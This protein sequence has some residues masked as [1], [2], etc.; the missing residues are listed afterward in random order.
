MHAEFSFLIIMANKAAVSSDKIQVDGMIFFTL[1]C[2]IRRLKGRR[3]QSWRSMAIRNKVRSVNT[4]NAKL[5]G[6][7]T[8]QIP[9]LLPAAWYSLQSS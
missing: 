4:R 5:E 8:L 7:L 9:Q 6:K 1:F 3:T 2:V